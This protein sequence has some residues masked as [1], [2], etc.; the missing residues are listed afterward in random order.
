MLKSS[1]LIAILRGVTP[2]E[3]QIVCDALYRAGILLVEIPLNSPSAV[4]SISVAVKH[5]AGRQR[6]GAGTVLSPFDVQAVANAGGEYIISPNTN[7]DVIR[8]TKKQGLISIPGFLTPSEGFTAIAAGAD[9]LKLFPAGNF[10]AGYIKNLKAVIKTPIL[11]VGGVNTENL[12]ELL[13]VCP[14]AGIGGAIYKAGMKPE[15]VEQN[16]RALMAL[17]KQA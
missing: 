3:V 1:P 5:C 7:P 11:A 9:Y 15:Q 16:A 12:K 14:G 10:G 8:A 4:K 17:V 13:A 6:I 2:D